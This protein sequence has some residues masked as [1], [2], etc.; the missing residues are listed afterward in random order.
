MAAL[1]CLLCLEKVCEKICFK[2]YCFV[3]QSLC[4]L[5]AEEAEVAKMGF[6][7]TVVETADILGVEFFVSEAY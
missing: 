7:P 5:E 2:E 1:V 3:K 4:E 6:I